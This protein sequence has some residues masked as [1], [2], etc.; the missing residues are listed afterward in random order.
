MLKRTQNKN[1]PDFIYIH[2]PRTGGT[3]LGQCLISEC[4]ASIYKWLH[5][6][7]SDIDVPVNNAFVFGFVRNPYSREYSYY[8]LVNPKI[9][10]NEWL[11][12][13]FIDVLPNPS[14]HS[15]PQHTYYNESCNVFKYEDRT[16][17]LITIAEKIAADKDSLLSYSKYR[18]SYRGTTDYR[19]QYDN[20]SYD[21]VT[22]YCAEDISKYGYLFD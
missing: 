10:F 8:T 1:L 15:E 9:T 19:T 5:A 11:T 17:S 2:C 13:R 12:Q 16:S 21:I 7:H 14:R 4:S 20:E 3:S 6:K 22:K 18:N